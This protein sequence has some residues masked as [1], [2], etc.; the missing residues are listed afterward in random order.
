MKQD[1]LSHWNLPGLSITAL[2]LFVVCFVAYAYWTYRK[3][4]KKFYDQA[5]LIPLE[6]PAKAGSFAKGQRI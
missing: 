1:V 5:S 4:N 6:D 2:I 3:Q